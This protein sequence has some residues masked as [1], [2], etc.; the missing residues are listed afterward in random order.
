MVTN[1]YEL[2]LLK[3]FMQKDVVT[4]SEQRKRSVQG[5]TVEGGGVEGLACL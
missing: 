1:Y 4:P 3:H 5:M 2:L